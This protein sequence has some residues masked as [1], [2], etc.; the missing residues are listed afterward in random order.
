[1]F[2]PLK[3]YC[4]CFRMLLNISYR[5]HVS[6]DEV[7][8]KIKA[9]MVKIWNPRW[10]GHFSRSFQLKRR[11]FRGYNGRET[12]KNIHRRDGNTILKSGQEQTLSAQIGQ[13]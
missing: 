7:R 10:L 4:I 8:R 9:A 13:L 12:K 6:N 2:E 5:D 11:F 1:M 3:F